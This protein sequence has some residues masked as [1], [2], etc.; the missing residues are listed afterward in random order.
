[1]LDVKRGSWLA[2]SQQSQLLRPFVAQSLQFSVGDK[3][4]YLSATTGDWLFTKVAAVSGTSVAVALKP[5]AWLT[6]EMQET[7]LRPVEKGATTVPDVP[8]ELN[9]NT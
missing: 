2:A 6:T 1:M 3:V 8:V 9:L 5:D 7:R 4:V